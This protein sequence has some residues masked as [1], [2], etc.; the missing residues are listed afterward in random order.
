MST[1]IAALY[2]HALRSPEAPALLAPQ[3]LVQ[4]SYGELSTRVRRLAR[5]LGEI[6][7]DRNG[8]TSNEIHDSCYFQRAEN[9]R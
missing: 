2:R 6:N 7:V 9:Q 8:Q 1:L 5:G 4:W 3:Q